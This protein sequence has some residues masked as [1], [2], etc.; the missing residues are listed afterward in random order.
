MQYTEIMRFEMKP[1][2]YGGKDMDEH[3]PQWNGYAY[4]DK[5]DDTHNDP[6][7]F[8]PEDFPLSRTLGRHEKIR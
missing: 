8:R 7:V 4:G 3:I 2:I 6:L 5:Q 1:Y